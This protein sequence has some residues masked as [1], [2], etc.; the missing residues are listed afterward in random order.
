MMTELTAKLSKLF[1]NMKNENG[2]CLRCTYNKYISEINYEKSAQDQKIYYETKKVCCRCENVYPYTN[3]KFP[4]YVFELDNYPKDV[5]DVDLSRIIHIHNHKEF[6]GTE[7][8]P[9][10]DE[11][12]KCIELTIVNR[13]KCDFCKKLSDYTEIKEHYNLNNPCDRMKELT[14]KEKGRIRYRNKQK[15]KVERIKRIKRENTVENN[16]K[17]TLIVTK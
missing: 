13:Y 8:E 7:E 1:E 9:K 10:Y 12:G 2:K 11:K 4:H 16:N 5:I 14:K 15:N 17:L 3:H 6:S